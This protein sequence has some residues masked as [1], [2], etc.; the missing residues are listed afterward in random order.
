MN[1]SSRKEASSFMLRTHEQQGSF[2]ESSA[3][4]SYQYYH[5]ITL[6]SPPLCLSARF[7][8]SPYLQAT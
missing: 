8:V 3:P 2:Y 1:L 6:L 5:P 7:K 4:I